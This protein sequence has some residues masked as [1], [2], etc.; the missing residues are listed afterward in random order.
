MIDA[1]AHELRSLMS[2]AQ[3]LQNTLSPQ[4][5]LTPENLASLQKLDYLTQS[6]DALS[7]IWLK[8]KDDIPDEISIGSEDTIDKIGLK[9]LAAKL[10]GVVAPSM[11]ACKVNSGELEEF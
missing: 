11:A 9:D 7:S 3:T 4:R 5:E 8:L 2:D 6:L 1:T 10:K